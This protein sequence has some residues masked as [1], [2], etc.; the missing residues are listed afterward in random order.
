L[1]LYLRSSSSICGFKN[2]LRSL[3]KFFAETEGKELA[4]DRSLVIEA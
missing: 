3:H 1:I 2:N 4:K